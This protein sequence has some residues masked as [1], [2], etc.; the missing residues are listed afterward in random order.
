[1]FKITEMAES[2]G[3]W[4]SGPMRILLAVFGAIGNVLAIIVFIKQKSKRT[5]PDLI[6]I[7]N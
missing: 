2:Y 1:M 3:Y 7:G 4:M 6:R 5:D